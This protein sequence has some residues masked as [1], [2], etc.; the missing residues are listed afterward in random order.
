[1]I[2]RHPAD[3]AVAVRVQRSRA[4]PYHAGHVAGV[5]WSQEQEE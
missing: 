5:S 3:T 2:V 1:M 4:P